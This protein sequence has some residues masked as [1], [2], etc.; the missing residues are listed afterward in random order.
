MFFRALPG[1]RPTL[2]SARGG[3]N[4]R[5]RPA[6]GIDRASPWD[7]RFDLRQVGSRNRAFDLRQGESTMRPDLLL[8][9]AE[10]V[11]KGEPFALAVV[12]RREP[13]TS[14]R[15]RDLPLFTPGC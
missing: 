8:L 1:S 10:L 12:V 5:H 14:A 13:A 2:A 4:E 9:A 15:V 7:I 11:K 3:V 6:A